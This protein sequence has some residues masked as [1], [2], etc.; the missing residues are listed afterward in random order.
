[1]RILFALLVLT[2]TAMAQPA[3]PPVAPQQLPPVQPQQPTPNP[4]P[5]AAPFG[6]LYNVLSGSTPSPQP[7]QQQPLTPFNAAT[8]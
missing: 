8:P 6:G 5:V 4:P 3:P 7:G 2:A 1:M